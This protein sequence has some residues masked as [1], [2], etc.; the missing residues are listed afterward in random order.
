MTYASLRGISDAVR[1]YHQAYGAIPA[2]L[3]DLAGLENGYSW[4]NPNGPTLDGWGRPFI[5][6]R[7]E[8]GFEVL[9]F[10]RDGQPGGVGLDA[11]LST[12]DLKGRAPL[13]TLGQFL[14]EL[15]TGTIVS[16]CLATGALGAI[17]TFYLVR[18]PRVSWSLMGKIGATVLAAGVVAGWMMFLHIPTGH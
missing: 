4:V 3:S 14:F 2:S 15:P 5:Y 10:G 16:W 7:E 13:P 11:D 6:L 1:A 17:L 12:S 9:S 18:S 8:S